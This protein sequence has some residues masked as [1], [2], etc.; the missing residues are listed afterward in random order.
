MGIGLRAAI[1][2]LRMHDLALTKRFYLDY[3][4]FSLDGQD[5]EGDRPIFMK[6]SR[7]GMRL[8]LSSHRDDGT[9]GTVVLVL[10]SDVAALHAELAAKNYPFLNPGLEPDALEGAWSCS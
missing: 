1:P 4:G 6:V 3:L 8:H 10:T 2:I 9:P 7:D 5:G